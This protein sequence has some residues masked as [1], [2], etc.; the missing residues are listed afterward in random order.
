RPG[1]AL[2]L[3]TRSLETDLVRLPVGLE[4]AVVNSGLRHSHATGAYTQRQRECQEAAARLGVAALRD[5][6][7]D[8]RAEIDA[9]PPPLAQ[10]ARHVVTENARV[11]K[12]TAALRARNVVAFGRLLDASHAS[13]R[14]DYEVSVSG[15][16]A[17]VDI[18]KA[19]RGVLGAR[20]TG[21]GFGG[22]IV[23]ATRSGFAAQVAQAV[24]RRARTELFLEAT[25][26]VPAAKA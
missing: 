23:I 25:V 20:L 14:D 7:E 9:L 2:F 21:G 13:L 22:A 1:A 24:A 3:D 8:R 19:Q 10:R 18:A 11:L 15:I 5:V 26:V 4:I 16:D 12:A 6:A 17:M